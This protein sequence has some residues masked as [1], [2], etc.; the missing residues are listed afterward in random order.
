MDE[1]LQRRPSVSIE[2]IYLP[3]DTD[4]PRA[5]ADLNFLNTD[6][7]IV[8]EVRGFKLMS[9]PNGGWWCA[10][11]QRQQRNGEWADVFAWGSKDQAEEARHLIH[12]AYKKES[13]K[14]SGF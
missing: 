2:R 12:E 1:P 11:P 9:R 10:V 3:P 5:I 7:S 8:C 13:E 6:G 4:N 14:T